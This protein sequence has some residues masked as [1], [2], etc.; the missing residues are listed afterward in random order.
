[1]ADA[2]RIARF[3]LKDV[4]RACKEFDLLAA[5]D[6]VAVAV[7]GGKDSRT[8][9][10]LLLRYRE[11]LPCEL[12]ALHVVGAHVGL[13]DLRE[14]LAPWFEERGVAYHF[15]PL[16]LGPADQPPL[17]CFRCSRQRRRALLLAADAQGCNK[18]ALGHHADDAAV[19]T[20]L[21][22]MFAGRAET[23]APRVDLFGGQ[24]VLIRPLIYVPAKEIAYYARAAG[25]PPTPPCPFESD[26]NRQAVAAF[27][28]S[29]GRQQR[30]IRANLWRAAGKGLRPSPGSAPAPTP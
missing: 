19:T 15:V 27:L 3:L 1:M 17:D 10:D 24:I 16:E 4:A 25:F 26:T 2:E 11:R 5:G 6:R 8:L 28:R 21:N 18:L 7:S 20:L 22:L 29:F 13:P 14:Q 9:L 12:V 30:R 23:L